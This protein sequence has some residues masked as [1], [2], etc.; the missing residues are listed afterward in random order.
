M[1]K[2]NN[3]T[4]ND[5]NFGTSNIVKVYR[6]N[7]I[8]YY[9]V[10]GGGDTPTAQTPCFAVV[11]NISQYSDREFEDVFNNADGK[12]YKKNNLN[13]YEEYGVYGSGRTITYYEGKLTID[14]EIT[15]S[16]TATCEY[17]YSGS[18]WVNVGEVSGGTATLPNKSFVLNYNAKD[19][20]A[21]T[22]SIPYTSGQ[23]K[24]IDAIQNYGTNTIV[25]HSSDG[26]ISVT[27]NTRLAIS[28]GTTP[29]YRTN[30]QARCTM[31]IVSKARTN[32]DYSI[33][34]CR[35]GTGFAQMNWMWRYP[36]NGIF[37]HGSTNYNAVTYYTN[38][39]S[40]P[41]TASVRVS[42]NGGVQQKIDDWTNND[43]YSGA[44]E[45]GNYDSAN[46]NGSLFCDYLTFNDEF[47]Q[48][49]FYWVYMSQEVLTDAE[50][51]QVIAY[52]EGS[53]GETEYPM[54]YSVMQ[55][56]PNNLVFS[57]MTEAESYE[58]PWVGMEVTINGSA[59]TFTSGYTWEAIPVDYSAQYLTLVAE[60]DDVTFYYSTTSSSNVLQYSLDS[61]TTW[62]N[63]TNGNSTTAIDSGD[64][65]M[66]KASGLTVDSERGIG[67]IIPSASASIEGNIM[68]LIYGDN[69]SGQTTIQNNYQF[70]KLFSGDTTITSAEN[71]VMPATTVT[72][73]CYSQMFQG[74]SNL[75]KTPK[76]IG[77]STMTWNG[78]FCWSDMFNSCTSLTTVPS[79]LLPATNLSSACYWC[80]FQNCT[81]LTTA[82]ILPATTLVSN[83]Y[84]SMFDGC[85]NLN[86]IEAMFT[87]SPSSSY[88][89]NWVN[90]V[91]SSGTFVKNSSATWTS[92]C[93][94]S[95]YPCNW[96]IQ[97]SNQ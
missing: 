29:M 86:Y 47:W 14:E 62:N 12:W 90:G 11:D 34:T 3:N 56:P 94:I 48:G 6:N 50:I 96:T 19:Y 28:G 78:D 72:K 95:T 25:D 18:S 58:C 63:L 77:S 7:A 73:Q 79:G 41:I 76:T 24:A 83:C 42:W 23:S 97:Y 69:F 17:I 71:M 80:L 5:W 51:Q 49:D 64:K 40:S 4:I 15:P 82:P 61:G 84:L 22:H 33:L 13:Q 38:T 31:T 8:C 75:T 45:Y 89:S 21:S 44:F 52:N 20:D 81:S 60:T 91:A 1:I 35:G 65:V 27:G 55:D 39:T 66:F 26:Y 87:T 93:G 67:K 37:L 88:M 2:Y 57:S 53:G 36:S 54:Y 92:S 16:T 32:T 59:Y 70:R 85:S 30:T 10:S 68:S 9:K 74:C 43:S 46:D